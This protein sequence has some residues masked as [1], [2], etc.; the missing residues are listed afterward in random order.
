M[1]HKSLSVLPTLVCV[2]IVGGS[3]FSERMSE[4]EVLKRAI[5]FAE[6]TLTFRNYFITLS[7][8]IIHQLLA[9]SLIASFSGT[10]LSYKF[11]ENYGLFLIGVFAGLLLTTTLYLR[12]VA[13]KLNLPSEIV[14][15][16]DRRIW[17]TVVCYFILG[18]ATATI[19]LNSYIKFE[20]IK[21]IMILFFTS[22]LAQLAQLLYLS[23]K[24]G[25]KV[26]EK[27]TPLISLVNGVL[28][29]LTLPIKELDLFLVTLTS[30]LAFTNTILLTTIIGGYF[31]AQRRI[32]ES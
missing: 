16:E 20:W 21:T 4:K 1:I 9:I 13:R 2:N 25:W 8:T 14:R 30:Y 18:L 5:S 24:I 15:V 12:Y 22:P 32:L 3:H 23:K 6:E 31:W 27:V 17:L 26:G 10:L 11:L 29:A 28:G 19:I 7:I